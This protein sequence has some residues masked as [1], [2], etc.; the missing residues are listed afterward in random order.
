MSVGLSLQD[1]Y[2]SHNRCFGCGPANDRGLR[3]KSHVAGD[4]V[5][6]EWTPERYHKAFDGGVIGALFDCRSTFVAVQ[7]SHPAYHRR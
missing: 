6:A 2:A 1:C 4:E 5:V 3:I 7:E